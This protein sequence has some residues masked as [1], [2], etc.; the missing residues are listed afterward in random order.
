MRFFESVVLETCDFLREAWP[1]E[2]DKL[3][4]TVREMPNYDPGDK[5]IRRF[6]YSKAN[7]SIVLYRVP[8]QRLRR[9][10]EL[11]MEIERAVLSAVGALIDRDPWDLLPRG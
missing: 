10:G 4:W 8:I 9:G 7:M 5:E 11:R 3:N 2:L 6:G 1:E